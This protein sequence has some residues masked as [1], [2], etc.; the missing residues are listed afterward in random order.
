MRSTL[1]EN[2][3]KYNK[4][5]S[6]LLK[7]SKCIECCDPSEVSHFQDI[8]KD[9]SQEMRDLKLQIESIYDIKICNC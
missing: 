6:D 7:M 3:K 5:K 8:C 9:Y 2:V 1:E 4:I